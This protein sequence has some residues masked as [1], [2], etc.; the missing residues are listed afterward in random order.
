M[1]QQVKTCLQRRRHGRWWVQSLC[2]EDPWRRK[3][4]AHS[5]IFTSKVPWTEELAALQ[6]KGSQSVRHDRVNKHEAQWSVFIQFSEELPNWFPSKLHH[7]TFPSAVPKGSYF[8]SSFPIRVI[9][10]FLFYYNGRSNE[11]EVVSHCRIDLCY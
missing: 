5:S 11:C 1:A 2:W 9:F 7:L 10:C 6:S 3:M 8:L 4:A